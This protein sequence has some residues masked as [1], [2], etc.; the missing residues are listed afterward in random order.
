MKLYEFFG[1]WQ[2]KS[3]MD[4]DNPMDKNHDGEVTREEKEAF[5]N[6]LFFYIIDNDDIHKENFFKI[7]ETIST[8]KET[9]EN[10]WLPMVNKGCM[11]FYRERHLQDDPKDLFNKEF[12]EGL[13]KMLDDHFRKDVIKGEYRKG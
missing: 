1:T 13:C 6:D 4:V 12:R 2:A 10:V 3:P 7:A 11:E 8:N 9:S 5:K